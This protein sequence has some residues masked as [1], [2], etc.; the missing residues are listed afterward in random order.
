MTRSC[1]SASSSIFLNSIGRSVAMLN[2]RLVPPA[3]LIICRMWICARSALAA[4]K[5]G[6]TV[7]L[8]SSSCCSRM[9]SPYGASPSPHGHLPPTRVMRAN[10]SETIRPLPRSGMPPSRPSLPSAKRLGQSQSTASIL[11]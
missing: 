2:M 5:R 4:R 10:I 1:G 8:R 6:T 3:C 7:S 11:T 9:T